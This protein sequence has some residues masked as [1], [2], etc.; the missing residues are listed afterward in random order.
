MTSSD[1]SVR[2]V[3][4]IVACPLFLQNLDTTVMATALPA[5][6]RSLQ[7]QV[8]DLNLAITSYLL[9]LAVFLPASAW[10]SGRVGARRVFCAAV[11][12]FSLG[13]ALCGIAGTL[14]QLVV[15]RLLQG[16]GGAMMVPVGRSIL[17]RTVPS[18]QMVKAMVWFTIPGAV[19][20]L[21]GPL[22]G[23]A[24][25]TVTSWRWIFLVNIPF[26]LAGVAAALAFIAKDPETDPAA[27]GSFDAVG[28]GILATG[29]GGVLGGL[30]MIGKHLLPW[31]AIA[32]LVGAGLLAFWIYARRSRGA[33]HPILDFGVLRFPTFRI[34]VVGGFPLRV[35]IGAAPFLL[36]LMLQVGFGLSP[37]TSGLL[38]MGLA[39]GS[40]ATRAALVR[41][42][43]AF[44]FRRIMVTA[45][46]LA[47]VFYAAYGL[48]TPRTPHAWM[49]VVLVVGGLW[50][51]MAMVSM[52]TLGFSD[53]PPARA[54]HATALSAMGQ[55]VSIALGVVLGAAIVAG[56]S[57]LHG[58]GP[59]ELQPADFPPAFDVVA[60]LALCSAIAF[61][62]LRPEDG[63]ELSGRAGTPGGR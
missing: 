49:F 23:G 62:R 1:R 31:P 20:R 42:I 16:V 28:L 11:L 34:A 60:L 50:T 54:G 32:A 7:V 53:I 37:L 51:S 25:V 36:P 24:I 4:L 9:S 44:G 26:G 43:R 21:V 61:T 38:A 52:N 48:F 59:G 5:I 40:L 2:L 57:L 63:A 27:V 22:F 12:L 10:L 19:G 3:P 8:L 15:C 41:A 56:S 13:S 6:S 39:V 18:E 55:Q 45:G 17:L 30:E 46:V 58:R 29:L 33:A 14:G 47:S 35:A